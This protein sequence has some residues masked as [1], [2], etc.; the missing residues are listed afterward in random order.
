MD[1]KSVLAKAENLAK[2]T[3]DE[4]KFVKEKSLWFVN[5]LSNVCKGLKAKVVV[6][7]SFAKGT[8]LR[9]A[10]DVDVYVCFDY[11]KFKDKS[12]KLSDLLEKRVKRAFRNYERLH[13][14]RDYFRVKRDDLIFEIIPILA[15]RNVDEAVN[16]TDVSL[17]HV[18]WVK[19]KIKRNRKLADQIRLVKL[20]CKANGVY[21]AESYI[22]GFSGYACEILTI[23]S[24]GFLDLLR[25]A[26]NWF[27]KKKILLDPAKHYKN[28]NEILKSINV[29]KLQSRLV[30]V[31]PVQKDR[32]VTAALSDEKF[33]LF[34]LAARKF[35]KKPSLDFFVERRFELNNLKVLA[36]KKN[37]YL[38]IAKIIPFDGKEDVVGSKLLKAFE[39]LCMNLVEYGFK[40]KGKG[41]WWDKAKEAYFWFMFKEVPLPKEKKLAGPPIRM[42]REVEN[43]RRAHKRAKFFI[44]GG[45][46][47]A[48]VKRSFVK[49]EQLL[50]KLSKNEWIKKKVKDFS[51]LKI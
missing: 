50:A 22:R 18:K 19:S 4:E 45:R 38:I 16:I 35:L 46:I 41:W 5:R 23:Q 48:V 27:G 6:G 36:N 7:G 49:P 21:G 33:R 25:N 51:I 43:F 15:I 34:V 40:L 20:F 17:F 11:N 26:K 32:N 24:G 10:K 2:P 37:L 44:K 8:W 31:D 14:S 12:D 29:A 39:Y 13:G 30:I 3:R 47:Y 28:R 9:G 1:F 42:K